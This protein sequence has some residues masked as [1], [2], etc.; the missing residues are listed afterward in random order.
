MR[1]RSQNFP[2]SGEEF[3]LFNVNVLLS[4]AHFSL[5]GVYFYYM[6]RFLTI[7]LQYFDMVRL[8]HGEIL[9][10]RGVYFSLHAVKIYISYCAS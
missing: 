5:R 6:V 3:L 9:S 1:T 7:W 4:D 8:F 10:L 2:L